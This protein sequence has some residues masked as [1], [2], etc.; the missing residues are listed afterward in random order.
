[1]R[2]AIAA[3][4]ASVV[5]SQL[6][7]CAMFRETRPSSTANACDIFEE[8]DDWYP[9]AHK[10]E[11][12]WGVPVALQLA[13]IKQESGFEPTAKPPRRKFLWL[14]PTVRPSNAYGYGQV[15]D[16]TWKTYRS[17]TGRWGADR[18][19]FEDVADFIGW[20][21]ATSH[22]KLGIAKSDAYNQY[23]AYHEGQGG[24]QRGTYRGKGWLKDVARN[25]EAQTR[26]YQ[27]QLSRCADRLDDG[28]WW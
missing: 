8:K 1:M 3:L 27:D 5:L 17:E 6:S 9:A 11:K 28:S 15:L 18:D 26:R 19:E 25:V 2:P 4:L 12:R 21:C 14:I 13:I 22:D 7:A 24:Y 16:S 23:L 20:Y 10:A